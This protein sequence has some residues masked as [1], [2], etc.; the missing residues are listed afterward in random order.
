[1]STSDLEF[2]AAHE[3]IWDAKPFLRETY[4]RYHRLLLESCSPHA[5]VL[6]LGC[7]IGKL[8]ER[9]RAEGR[10]R[11]VSSDIIAAPG[12]SLRCDGTALPV[13]SGALDHIVFVDVLHH[14]PAPLEFFSEAARALRP[15]GSIVCVEPWVT[16]FSYPI[17]RFIHHEGCDLSRDVEAPFRGGKQAYDGDNGIPRLLCKRLDVRRWA[18]LGFAPAAV[19][20]FN[21]FA[22][23][24]TRGF[25]DTR[26]APA[27]VYAAARIGIDQWLAPLAPVLGMRARIR[28]KR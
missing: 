10:S 20:P 16:A 28:W 26:D 11:W 1:M 18:E 4:A 12:A 14:L 25:R 5:R 27:F 17:Y 9:A 6:E 8:G 19:E 15:G 24:A 22:Y 13:R 21:D 7:G 2:I 23:L 3:R